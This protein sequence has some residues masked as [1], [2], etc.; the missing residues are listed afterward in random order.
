MPRLF[1][2]SIAAFAIFLY[3]ADAW[4][5]THV[6]SVNNNFFSPNELTIKTGDTVKWV[7]DSGTMHDV[8][9]DTFNWSSPTAPFFTYE[10][11]FNS[12]GVAPYHCSV[13]SQHGQDIDL[14]MNGR[15]NIVQGEEQVEDFLINEA[16]GDA[17]FDP[18][19]D[20]QGFFIVIWEES[21][22]VFLSWFT[23]DAQRP[24]QDADAVLGEPGQRWL[25][26]QG[27]Y[28]G[29]KATLDL[30]VTS[31]GVFDSGEPG[32]ETVQDGTMEIEFS[33][34]NAGTV[35]YEIASLDISGVIPIE[36]IVLDKVPACE[37]AQT[38]TR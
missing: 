33:G 28:E 36:R 26:A 1:L 4:T 10:R 6:I 31:G 34:C 16:I 23:F 37:A 25:T 29:D 11:T 7:N 20:G 27:A 2:F 12:V 17:W 18:Q 32:T 30:F 3:S 15:I 14:F 5:E 35:S 22:S 9:S 19:T 21:K 38:T 24:P 8:A 13:H